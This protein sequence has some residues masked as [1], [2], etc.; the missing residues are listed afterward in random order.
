MPKANRPLDFGVFKF[1]SICSQGPKRFIFHLQVLSAAEPRNRL[2]LKSRMV[3]EN[4]PAEPLQQGIKGIICFFFF[5]G[6]SRKWWFSPPMSPVSNTCPPR[7]RGGIEPPKRRSGD[8]SVSLQNDPKK[9]G[10]PKNDP[11][12]SCLDKS[13]QSILRFALQVFVDALSIVSCVVLK[14]PL[15]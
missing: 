9:G 15:N 4:L 7:Y 10:T 13:T 5:L 12:P 1:F 14:S 8:Q 6:G 3:E 2:L 11:P